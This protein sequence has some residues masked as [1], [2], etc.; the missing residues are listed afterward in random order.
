M[1][2]SSSKRGGFT[3]IEVIIAM[4]IFV[5][6]AVAIVRIFPPALAALQGSQDRSNATRLAS[7]QIERFRLRAANST[8][9]DSI[10]NGDTNGGYDD[11]F[12]GAFVG[13]VNSNL[14]LPRNV[15]KGTGT[16]LDQG[17]Y[18][19]GERQREA[20]RVVRVLA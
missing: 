7:G 6:G 20:S 5:I 1:R 8:L 12:G 18:I 19:D 17:R 13:T 11:S 4:A 14:S 9:P 2:V 3:L 10:Y 16:A 15:Q